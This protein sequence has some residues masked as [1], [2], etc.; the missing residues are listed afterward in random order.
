GARGA[1]AA[2][3]DQAEVLE[4]ALPQGAGPELVWAA[5]AE[6]GAAVVHLAPVAGNLEAAFLGAIA[7]EGA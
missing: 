6:A 5:A 2:A 4:V 7:E 1:D 3:A